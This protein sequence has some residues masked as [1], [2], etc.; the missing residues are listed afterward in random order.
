MYTTVLSP[1]LVRLGRVAYPISQKA[2]DLADKRLTLW[3]TMAAMQV[4]P[5]TDNVVELLQC[6][7]FL[8]W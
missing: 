7:C 4:H 6:Y 3:Q 1:G 5:A 2:V 8:F